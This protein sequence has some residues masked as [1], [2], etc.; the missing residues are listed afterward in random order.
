MERICQYKDVV[1]TAKETREYVGI[2]APTWMR[3]GDEGMVKWSEQ[4]SYQ[5]HDMVDFYEREDAN[6]SDRLY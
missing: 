3:N 4:K 5:L 6:A 2:R 1:R